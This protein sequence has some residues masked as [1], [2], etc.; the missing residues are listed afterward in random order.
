MPH[1]DLMLGLLRAWLPFASYTPHLIQAL[2]SRPCRAE[3]MA[4]APTLLASGKR[5]YAFAVECRLQ[6]KGAVQAAAVP[7]THSGITQLA[8]QRVGFMH[9]TTRSAMLWQRRAT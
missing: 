2:G 8:A 1:F 9:A 3:L 5:L 7:W 6:P 4:R